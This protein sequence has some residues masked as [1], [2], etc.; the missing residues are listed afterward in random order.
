MASTTDVR[1][2]NG[3][4]ALSDH[5][6]HHCARFGDEN[7][8]EALPI[9]LLFYYRYVN[10][11]ALAVS[12]SMFNIVLNIF[13]SF[14]PRLR[15]RRGPITNN[16]IS[17]TIL[18]NNLYNLTSTNLH[19]QEDT[20]WVSTSFLPKKRHSH[21]LNWQSFQAL[22]FE[23]PQRKSWICIVNTLLNNEYPLSFIFQIL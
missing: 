12:S 14:H 15:W 4:S 17:L 7:A 21:R 1:Y 9:N 5:C 19:I 23:I 18:K 16:W 13:N 10:D 8:I 22:S 6:R 11:V 20:F 2:T 3:L